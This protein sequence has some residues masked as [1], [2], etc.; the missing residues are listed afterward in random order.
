[1]GLAPARY[2]TNLQAR[3]VGI[4]QKR[5]SR[6]GYTDNGR[7]TTTL[8]RSYLT[9]QPLA[10]LLDEKSRADG[11]GGCQIYAGLDAK[12]T[13]AAMAAILAAG[14][15]TVLVALEHHAIHS[16]KAMRVNN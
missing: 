6:R 9:L 16:G 2:R 14:P 5:F 13:K 10:E 4:S 12:D 15:G 7:D 1:M 3:R 8:Q 11:R